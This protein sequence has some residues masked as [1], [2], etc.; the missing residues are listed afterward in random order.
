MTSIQQAV[1]EAATEQEIH[2]LVAAYAKATRIDDQIKQLGKLTPGVPPSEATDLS[3]RVRLLF[4]GLEVASKRL[5][6][7]SRTTIKEALNVFCQALLRLN[8]L[9]TARPETGFGSSSGGAESDP[10]GR[11]LTE[12]SASL[13]NRPHQPATRLEEE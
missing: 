2:R 8:E 11:R 7:E 1:Q 3:G 5:D 12:R 13:N 10:D 4:N 6:D 9:Q